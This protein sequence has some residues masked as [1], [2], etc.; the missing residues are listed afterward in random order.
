[1]DPI[2]DVFTA[3]RV[4][5]VLYGRI[6]A[7]APWGFE[8]ESSPK[9][10]FGTVLR[11]SCWLS[12]SGITKQIAL[13][14][15]DC[16]LIAPG[17]AYA[18]RDHP[19]SSTRDITEIVAGQSGKIIHWGGSG[20]ASTIIGG[21]FEFDEAS[22]KP[23]MELLPALIHIRADRVRTTG[24]QTT[25][26][27]LADET[28]APGAGSQVVVNRLADL[29]FIHAI[30]A[31]IA[32]D[33]CARTGW[34]HALSDSQIGKALRAIHENLEDS[35]TV[36]SLATVAGLSRSAFALRF[37]QLVG[38][39]PLEYLT[40]WRM[41]KASNLLRDRKVGLAEVAE[42][43]GYYSDAAFNKAFKRV[44]GMTPGEYR[45]TGSLVKA[46]GAGAAN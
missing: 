2:T 10:C 39:A 19:L 33:E 29:L 28:A 43:V 45:K 15:G 7:C 18:I 1:M 13:A 16:F 14:G 3:M 6:E 27:L 11:G 35:W 36:A 34:L 30:R 38:V 17:R 31:Y 25:L 21:T 40:R 5:S 44:L 32:S 23:L 4:Q 41:Y 8:A 42:Q 12:V 9:A 46:I 26:Q 24:L 20:P 22:S 37:K